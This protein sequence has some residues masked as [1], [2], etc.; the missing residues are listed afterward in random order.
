MMATESNIR[1]WAARFT[2]AFWLALILF[3]L[4]G[5]LVVRDLPVWMIAGVIA[6]GV[7]LGALFFLPR[8]LVKRRDPAYSSRRS[9]AAFAL[10]GVLAA[11]GLAPLPI[12][13]L[14]FWV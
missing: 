8:W 2:G 5:L 6:A 13:Y 11:T 10:A 1:R 7:A 9:F 14:A 12:Y 3:A 4:A